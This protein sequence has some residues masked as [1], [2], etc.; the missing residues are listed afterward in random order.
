MSS[1][2]T[3]LQKE[4]LDDNVKLS[5]SLNKAYVIA[6]KLNIPE[7]LE[8]LD[9]EI[10]GYP[11]DKKLPLYRITNGLLKAF[12]PYVGWI[13]L[14]A[15]EDEPYKTFSVVEFRTSIA[16]IEALAEEPNGDSKV[17][18]Q[19]L[20]SYL[21]P[22]FVKGGPCT[23][24]ARF[25]GTSVLAAI[26]STVRHALLEWTLKLEEV[27]I[28]GEGLSFTDKEKEVAKNTSLT[29]NISMGDDGKLNLWS[30]DNSS[31]IRN[32]NGI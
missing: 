17:L 21:I 13:A 1:I 12:N 26:L 25:I 31:N 19:S 6:R 14:V 24:L 22:K 9:C 8:F 28:A 23:E 32:K 3:E 29:I 15:T 27:G 11:E 2:V 4:L 30:T 5:S 18:K 20:P 7:L 10:K 16:E